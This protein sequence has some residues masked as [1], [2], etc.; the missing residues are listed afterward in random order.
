M[1]NLIILSLLLLTSCTENIRS[2]EYGGTMT[3][4]IPVDKK[5]VNATWKTSELWYLVRP[6][7]TNDNVETFELIEKSSFGVMQGKVIFQEQ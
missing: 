5:F 3:I 1:K 2:K 4:K 7:R 6:R